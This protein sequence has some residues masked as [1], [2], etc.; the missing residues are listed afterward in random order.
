MKYIALLR[1]I[2]VGGNNIIKM[3]DLKSA[4][5][6]CGCMNVSTYINSGN[7][8]FETDE[9][10]KEITEKLEKCLSETFHYTASFVLRTA[11]QM[12]EVVDGF[13][14]IW[15]DPQDWKC[16]VVFLKEP[17]TADQ[18]MHEVELKPDVDKVDV[19]K[20]VVYFSSRSG[21]ATSGFTKLMSKKIYKQLTIRN[22][23]TTQK[24]LELMQSTSQT[25]K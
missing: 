16:Y 20:T 21:V 6:K 22:L 9:S 11:K 7:V 15:K 24:L 13:P 10:E 25:T 23:N 3:A 8:I 12:Q 4:F 1:G 18:V 17:I 14:E 5:E 2:N 19:G